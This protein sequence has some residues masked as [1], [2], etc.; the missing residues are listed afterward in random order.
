MMLHNG[1]FWQPRE[2]GISK[3]VRPIKC[4]TVD[5]EFNDTRL[6]RIIGHYI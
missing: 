6:S 3:A 2:I 1:L 4:I 5:I